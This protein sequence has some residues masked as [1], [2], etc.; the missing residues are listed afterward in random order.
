MASDRTR[1][2]VA[3]ANP[4]TL[5]EMRTAALLAE[6][7]LKEAMVRK[8]G[9]QIASTTLH[10][11]LDPEEESGDEMDILED[12]T[13]KDFMTMFVKRQGQRGRRPP[14]PT[15]MGRTPPQTPSRGQKPK[16]KCYYCGKMGQ[17]IAR[18][19]NMKRPI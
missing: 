3:R 15:R 7:T 9:H 18:E 14:M 16:I 2:E 8:K 4:G 12:I 11:T 10:E 6:S 1:L 17:H 13:M 19:C 5:A